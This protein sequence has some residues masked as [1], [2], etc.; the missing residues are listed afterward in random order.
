MK[1]NAL[2]RG[3]AALHTH[4]EMVDFDA[5]WTW[6][7]KGLNDMRQKPLSLGGLLLSLGLFSLHLS[8]LVLALAAFD[9][10]GHQRRF[11]HLIVCFP[12]IGHATWHAYRSLITIED[13]KPAAPAS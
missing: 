12:L 2:K 7:S 11:P 10:R 13:P 9:E 4:I 3:G 5:P 1:L 8:A 6:M